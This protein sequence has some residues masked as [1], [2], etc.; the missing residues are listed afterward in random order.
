MVNAPD[1]DG[2]SPLHLA[3]ANVDVKMVAFLLQSGADVLAQDTHLVCPRSNCFLLPLLIWP[4][5]L[6]SAH[7]TA[8]GCPRQQRPHTWTPAP[9]GRGPVLP[10]CDPPSVTSPHV[11]TDSAQASALMYAA[12]EGH[13]DC[14]AVLLA[15]REVRVL[16][17]VCMCVS[18]CVIVAGCVASP[19]LC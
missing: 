10:V 15:S 19:V 18:V 2:R 16:I 5:T 11:R 7:A 12:V 8:L 13:V 9:A 4:S 3:V 17:T 14:V 6:M 1:G